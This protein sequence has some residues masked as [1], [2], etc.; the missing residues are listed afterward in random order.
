MLENLASDFLIAGGSGSVQFL[1]DAPAD[2]RCDC[3]SRPCQVANVAPN[4][5]S[6]LCGQEDHPRCSD[7]PGVPV[8]S[9][10]HVR[11]RCSQKVS[12]PVFFDVF[13]LEPHTDPVCR[14]PC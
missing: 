11:H 4:S 8:A 3:L 7:R 6:K 1:G 5:G 14:S 2:G 13:S 12:S 9:Q 10:E